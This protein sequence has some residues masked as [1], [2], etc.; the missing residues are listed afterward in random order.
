MLLNSRA[1][2]ATVVERIVYD[3]CSIKVA[4]DS[5]NFPATTETRDRAFI[6]ELVYGVC[7]WYFDLDH[8]LTQLLNKPLRRKDR[9]IKCLLLV[10]LY[11]IIH[12]D[13]P[14]HAVVQETVS[15][16][17]QLQKAWAKGLVNACLRQAIRN[18]LGEDRD[19]ETINARNQP[20][21]LVD[22][23]A[24]DWPQSHTQIL[25]AFNHR[26]PL[27][28]RVNLSKTSRE[29]YL[30]KLADSGL[31][32][33]A[34]KYSNCGIKVTP[35]VDA[36]ALPGF[37]DGLVSIQDEAAQLAA[38]I[39]CPEANE[40]VLDACAA[41]G[42]KAGHLLEFSANQIALTA[43]ELNAE[44]CQLIAQNLS[45]LNV[46]ADLISGDA[47]RPDTWWNKQSFDKILVDAPCSATG[48]LR[49]Q[50]DIKFH[51]RP[52]DI[53]NL[54]ELQRN[55]LESLWPLLRPGGT[56]LYATCSILNCENEELMAAFVARYEDC[57]STIIA[58]DWGHDTGLGRQILPGDGDMDGFYYCLLKK[59]E[60]GNY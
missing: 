26:P 20:A 51:R 47:L 46:S 55:I 43:L 17:K 33:S 50:P 41:P 56:L 3:H 13:T 14:N 19:N 2:A 38:S 24:Q 60:A 12:L 37:Y 44:R 22:R 18:K 11:Q 21:W 23:I 28:V 49:R 1:L 42:G 59:S 53:N 36:A 40:R 4:L 27:C 32:A 39:I 30:Q 34:T 58:Q 25:E 48:I 7:R 16:T 29:H 45:R 15:A 9:D 54:V 8:E 35:A 57:Q 6:Q 31:S 52:S 10:G 5:S